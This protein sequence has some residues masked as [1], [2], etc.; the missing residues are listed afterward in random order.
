MAA[1]HD[2]ARQEEK[3]ALLKEINEILSTASR[4]GTSQA[5]KDG[6]KQRLDIIRQTSAAGDSAKAK[7][8]AEREAQRKE[9][10]HQNEHRTF[11]R[12]RDP[13]LV[14]LIEGKTYSTVDWSLGGLLVG[15]IADRGWQPGQQVDVKI[16]LDA[17]KLHAERI[18]IVRYIAEG[19]RLAIKVRR[20][21]SV[22]MQIKR[23]CDQAGLDPAA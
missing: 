20:F 22:L 21:A 5:L 17:A 10:T 13:P 11:T 4:L 7:E 9:M 18:E 6:V 23:E 3:A 15:D 16:G 14:V 19:N 8:A 2:K 12:W 1:T